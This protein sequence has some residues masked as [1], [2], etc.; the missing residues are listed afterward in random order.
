MY[1]SKRTGLTWDVG[2]K[3]QQWQALTMSNV[4]LGALP[5]S[6]SIS[7]E[8]KQNKSYKRIAYDTHMG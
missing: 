8:T 4:K 7:F 3:Q 5:S 2:I 1:L 6:K